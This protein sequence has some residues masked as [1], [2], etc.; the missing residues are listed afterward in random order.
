M[1]RSYLLLAVWAFHLLI[2]T[3]AACNNGNTKPVLITTSSKKC[4][5]QLPSPSGLVNDY[6]QLFSPFEAKTLDSLLTNINAKDSVEI[7]V[8]AIDSLQLGTCNLQDFT[9]ELANSWGIGNKHTN[10]GVL[11]CIV[12]ILRQIR[13][14]NGLGTQ[15]WLTDVQT[16][17]LIN[18]IIIPHYRQA[19]YFEGT[20]QGILAIEKKA[21]EK[22][23]H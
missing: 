9:L 14:E 12:P 23:G 5:V 8:V 16:Q 1:K 4:A 15:V 18:D 6:I 22:T 21:Y 3:M 13:I 19:N 20:K 11:I 10:N 17:Q 2:L 7:A